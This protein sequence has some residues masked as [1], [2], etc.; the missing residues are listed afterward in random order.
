[1]VAISE[2]ERAWLEIKH[3]FE[4]Y[5]F[6]VGNDAVHRETEL[7]SGGISYLLNGV[8]KKPTWRTIRDVR[9]AVEKWEAREGYSNTE[10]A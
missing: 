10:R 7:S 1:M 9:N 8:T 6:R 4:R 3:R 2:R 5:A